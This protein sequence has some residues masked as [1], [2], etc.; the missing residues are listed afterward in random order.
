MPL[1][2]AIQRHLQAGVHALTGPPRGTWPWGS[3]LRV[4]RATLVW[5]SCSGCG[6]SL[7]LP[8]AIPGFPL[9]PP[10]SPASIQVHQDPSLDA[11]YRVLWAIL[12]TSV[13]KPSVSFSVQWKECS[14]LES[15]EK[16]IPASI[17]TFK[18]RKGPDL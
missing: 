9:Q 2:D 4:Q 14:P 12:L 13:K 6:T 10:G 16:F 15:L 7:V 11:Y 1:S 18:V 8:K 5:M 17:P 3:S